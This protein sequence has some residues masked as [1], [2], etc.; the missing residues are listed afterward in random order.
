MAR[1]RK[2]KEQFADLDS[3]YQ[4]LIQNMKDGEVRN[5]IAEVAMNQVE[6]MKMKKE[7]QH[8]K[9]VQNTAKEAG[10]QYRDGSK[11]NRL[12]IEYARFILEG[13]GKV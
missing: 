5:K 7:D 9:E 10:A 3:D 2:K 8:L 12:R 13:R 4:V 6:L 1:G 11:M